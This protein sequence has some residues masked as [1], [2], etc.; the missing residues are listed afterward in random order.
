MAASCSIRVSGLT[1]HLGQQE[2]LRALNLELGEGIYY[3]AG[4]NGSGKTTLLRCL[5]GLLPSSGQ[6]FLGP[7]PIETLSRRD[8]ARR[9]AYVPQ[10]LSLPAYL[11][12]YDFVLT[13]RFPYLNWL[14]Q[15]QPADHQR[16]ERSLRAMGIY[17]L[18]ERAMRQVSGGERQ[19]AIIARALVQE[20]GL[21]LLD[22]PAQSLDPRNKRELYARLKAQAATGSCIL[23]TTH[24]L[25]PLTD[26]AVKVLGLRAG[27]LV[28]NQPGNPGLPEQLMKEV[29]Q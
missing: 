12:L 23:C 15:Y 6:I 24:D 21:L 20:T 7:D 9:L 19:K 28:L 10:H 18:R 29:Y 13:G 14:G 2:I 17:E 25:E 5:A 22:E 1:A 11:R 26:P 3:L 8:I 27:Q 16:V 4:L